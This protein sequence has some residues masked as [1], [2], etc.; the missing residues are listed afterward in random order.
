MNNKE[1][2]VQILSKVNRTGIDHVIRWLESTDFYT[3]PA[4]SQYHGNHEGGL[5][6]HSIAVYNTLDR[7]TSTV[8]AGKIKPESV[9][10]T[11]LLHDVCKIDFYKKDSRN[12]KNEQGKWE[13][14]PYYSIDDNCPLGHGEKSVILLQSQGLFL[15]GDEIMAIRWH[16]GGFDDTARS[17]AGG[18]SLSKAM[19]DCPLL[20]T[21]HMADLAANYLTGV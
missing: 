2:F 15:T 6:E 17:Y 21:L 12:V 16:M 19:R 8:Y 5:C 3:A 10:I 7:I 20:V 13:R 1:I 14:V 11:A 4:S 9:I 18:L